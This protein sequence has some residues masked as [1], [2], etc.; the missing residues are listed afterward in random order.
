[1]NKFKKIICTTAVITLS[2]S[3]FAGCGSKKT[4]AT[5]SEE[6][7]AAISVETKT[8]KPETIEQY[9]NVSSKVLAENEISVLPK[10]SGTVKKVN[11]KLGDTVKAGDVLFEIDDTDTRIQVQ[12]AQA[13]VNSAQAGYEA[14]AGASLDNQVYQLEKNVENIQIQYN[15]LL[16]NLNHTKELYAV[17][18]ASKKEVD[19]LQSSVD[20]VKLQL[21][22]AKE[23]LEKTRNEI[24]SAT[25]NASQAQISQAQASLESAKVQL[26]RT[27]VVAEI[28]GVISS[29]NVTV[30]SI[31]SPQSPA[32]TIV[33]MDNVKLKLN[34]S[35]DAINKLTPGSKAYVTIS[36]ASDKVYEGT[37]ANISPAADS[38]TLL[39]PVEVYLTNTDGNIKPG[40]FASIKLVL[41][42]VENTISVPLN[43]VLEKSGEQYV[44]VVDE[45]T[46]TAVKTT[47]TTGVKNEENIE[48]LSGVKEGQ[49][50][51]IKGQDFI[52]DGSAVNITAAE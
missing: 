52:S 28:D 31:A 27:K 1:M 37:V 30:G 21:D 45:S 41:D 34:V 2:I 12:Q 4:S 43:A 44:F 7:V 29:C 11:F 35:D 46:N 49:K 15:D 19:D 32:M 9:I 25:R 6:Q 16:K 20:K 33:N 8:I 26:D 50:V 10:V 17:G 39:Y 38:Q 23:N 40:M 18:G 24:V 22:T 47:V 14:Q 5:T 51:V 42:N 48:I 13:A 3:S 36:A